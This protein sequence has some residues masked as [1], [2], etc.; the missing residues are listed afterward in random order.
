M[1][2]VYEYYRA[3][4]RDAALAD[5]ER[6][7]V[8]DSPDVEPAFDAV[9]AG[10]IDPEIEFCGLVALVLGEPYSV[11]LIG[12]TYLYPPP[13]GAPKSLEEAEALPEGSPYLEGPGIAEFAV[14]VRDALADVED[15][16]LWE[17]AVSWSESESYERHSDVGPHDL[18]PVIEEFVGLA[19]RAKEHDQQLYC[20]M[21][22]W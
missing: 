7:R 18:M 4:D 10:T 21:G 3:A 12:L 2:A 8:I 19:R 22:G 15:E 14:R 6:P 5:P 20:Y 13:E 1:G 9:D 11:D 17:L 16:R